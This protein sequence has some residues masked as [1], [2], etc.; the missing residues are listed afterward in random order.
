MM[1]QTRMLLIFLLAICFGQLQAAPII[2]G[3]DGQASVK[4][5]ESAEVTPK[6]SEVNQFLHNVQCTLEKA[7]P[8]IEDLETEAKRL[9]E[10]AKRVGLSIVN[11]FGDL[12]DSLL[13]TVGNRKP[14]AGADPGKPTTLATPTESTERDAVAD[15]DV[16]LGQV[17]HSTESPANGLAPN[18]AENEITNQE[19]LK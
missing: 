15:A 4:S 9:E 5:S 17:T 19:P 18:E 2:C 3:S 14:S 1:T 6:P 11:R 7:K 16:E 12:I 10:T 13:S 8:W